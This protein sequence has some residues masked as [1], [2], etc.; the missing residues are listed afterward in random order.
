MEE[1]VK[2][3]PLTRAFRNFFEKWYNQWRSVAKSFGYSIQNLFRRLFSY[4]K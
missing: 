1:P 2:Q 3:P 4:M